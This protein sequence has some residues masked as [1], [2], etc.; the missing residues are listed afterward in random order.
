MFETVV[1]FKNKQLIKKVIEIEYND[2]C[3]GHPFIIGKLY[4]ITARKNSLRN[5][6][7]SITTFPA[8]GIA[9]SL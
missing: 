5:Y 8:K 3:T 1:S 6:Y 2:N 9:D 4:N 7:E